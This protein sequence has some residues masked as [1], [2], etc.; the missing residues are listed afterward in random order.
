HL[1]SERE[2]GVAALID[3]V[4]DFD[5][6]SGRI[7]TDSVDAFLA[8]IS[9]RSIRLKYVFETHIHADHLTAAAYVGAK[10]GARIIASA[11]TPRTQALFEAVYDIRCPGNSFDYLLNDGETLPLGALT[12][13]AVATPGHTISCMT[14]L[15]EDCAFVGDTLFMPEYGTP[16]CDFPGG[17]AST[18]FASIQ[19]LY[20]LPD[21][22]RLFS[23]H[24]YLA[25]GRDHFAWESTIKEH[26]EHNIHLRCD[27]S[28]DAFISMRKARDA[29]LNAPKLMLPAVQVNICGGR[30]PRPHK[31]GTHYLQ[32]PLA[33]P[34]NGIPGVTT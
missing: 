20:A 9:S 10:T 17:D 18:L 21:H 24:D 19:K 7:W 5:G 26:R 11:A 2:S 25:P 8:D 16:R 12:L 4:L 15:I 22:I 28:R 34:K 29:K 31:N 13:K 23:A 6:A 1:V 33:P 3:P 32:L 27:T 14:L 30:L